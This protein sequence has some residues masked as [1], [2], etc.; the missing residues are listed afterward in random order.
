[1]G[2]HP[3]SSRGGQAVP[4]ALEHERVGAVWLG[5]SGLVA[6]VAVHST[7]LGPALGGTRWFPYASFEDGLADVLRLSRAMSYKAALAGLDF[8][9]GKA[10]VFG[11]PA[12]KTEA[13]L[14]DY[15]RFVDSFG[16]SY[17]TAEDVGTSQADMDVIGRV[18]PYVTGRSPEL[19][20]SG[21]PSPFTAYGVARAMEAAAEVVLGTGGLAGVHVVVN[22]V[23]KVGHGL[24]VLCEERGARLTI[25]DVSEEALKA[26]L[27]EVGA[28]VVPPGEAH[29]TPCDIYA[30]CALGGAL[31]AATAPELA[32]RVVC[33]G[34]NNQLATPQ[35]EHVLRGR[36][37]TYVPDYLANAGGI[38]NIAY[39]H[40]GYD[41]QRAR[42]HVGRIYDTTRSLL[43]EAR[44]SGGAVSELADRAAE[45][46][47]AAATR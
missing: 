3:S 7:A 23:G 13:M 38:I 45:A 15:G 21:D 41:P 27:A 44:A 18:T 24:A 39:E 2:E 20:G 37:I 10:V 34:A 46:R 36:G 4:L 42:E 9:G 33:G 32:C 35:V 16:G 28:E 43:E 26:T 29:R 14:E 11:H 40:G 31:S 22:G 30:P 1:M 5:G 8:G 6:I 19:G 17:L 12:D 25:A 47:M